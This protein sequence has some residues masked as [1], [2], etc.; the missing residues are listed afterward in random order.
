MIVINGDSPR[1]Q[2]ELARF[3]PLKGM[4]FLH[5]NVLDL[6][7]YGVKR[8]GAEGETRWVTGNLS[9]FLQRFMLDQGYQIVGLHDSVDGLQY[10]DSWMA[11]AVKRIGQGKEPPAREEETETHA[12]QQSAAAAS[13]PRKPLSFGAA[14]RADKHHL[15][16]AMNALRP[17]LANN[18]TSAVFIFDNASRLFSANDGGSGVGLD[19]FTRLLKATL[20]SREAIDGDTR[21][22]NLCIVVCDKLNDL[23]AFLYVDNPRTRAIHIDKPDSEARE[24]FIRS[25]YRAF[26][27]E[28]ADAKQPSDELVSRFTVSTEGMAYYELMSLVALSRE[29]RIPVESISD[30]TKQFKYGVKVSAWDTLDRERLRQAPALIGRRVKG[31]EVAMARV[32]DIIRRARVGLSLDTG[33]GNQRPRGVL[34]FAGPTGV[35][36]TEMAKG[37]AELLFGSEE[38]LLRFDMSEYSA[39]HADQRLLGA[40]P[41]YVGYEQGGQLTGALQKNPFS[42]VL[43]DEIEKAHPS[44]FDKFLQ[45]LDDGRLTDG[46]GETTYFSEC[47]IIFT[48]NLGV[49]SPSTGADGESGQSAPLLFSSGAQVEENQMVTPQM[50]YSLVRESILQAIRDHFNLKLGRPELLNRIGDNFVVFDFIRPPLDE[51]ILDMLLAR[52]QQVLSREQGIDLTIAEAVRAQLI[53]LARGNLQHGGRGIRNMLDSAL[54]NPLARWLFE[55]GMEARGGFEL[56]ELRDHGEA[57]PYR[58]ETVLERRA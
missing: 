18:V 46:K 39:A 24:R 19:V 1:W 14:P 22:N 43:F 31:Q 54:I 33:G 42:V 7:S 47:I 37:L 15:A 57:A 44:I 11:E 32:L 55:F 4:I 53:T 23:P 49:M 29:E 50:P 16:G 52:A 30:L 21:R 25:A 58:F 34:F 38:R 48:S 28:Q 5:G 6:V 56:I 17:V 36:K 9:G 45:I 41:G 20:E 27:S 51:E 10:S 2:K 40:P 12:A 13:G 26:H 3:I 35:G 8:D